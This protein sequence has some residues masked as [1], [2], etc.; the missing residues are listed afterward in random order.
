ME[1][2]ELKKVIRF[3]YQLYLLEKI[4]SAACDH[5]LWLSGRMHKAYFVTSTGFWRVK[6][7]TMCM[8]HILLK[9]EF[10]VKKGAISSQ[11]KIVVK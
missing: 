7:E 8:G 10:Y 5:Y 4:F 1:K 2:G 11:C 3:R 6:R 9:T